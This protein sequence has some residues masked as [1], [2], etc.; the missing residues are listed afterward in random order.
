[1]RKTSKRRRDTIWI[2]EELKRICDPLSNVQGI[3]CSKIYG[4]FRTQNW[5]SERKGRDECLTPFTSDIIQ[6]IYQ[7]CW[8][9]RRASCTKRCLLK[10]A[11]NCFLEYHSLLQDYEAST[12]YAWSWLLIVTNQSSCLANQ[13]VLAFREKKCWNH[14]FSVT[15]YLLI[16]YIDKFQNNQAAK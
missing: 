3:I 5:I 8:I 10:R 14:K 6:R 16:L 7:Y 1:M 9:K 4:L 2:F 15:F 13:K 11:Q 12:I